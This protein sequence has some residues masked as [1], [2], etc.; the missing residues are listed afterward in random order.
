MKF[1]VICPVYNSMHYL[2]RCISS[3]LNQSF[4]DFE[5]LLLDDGSTDNSLSIC[6]KYESI[7]KRIR[8]FSGANIGPYNERILGYKKS[9]G[10]YIL[11]I[12]SDDAFVKNAFSRIN[13]A[14]EKHDPDV[15][16][17]NSYSEEK[18]IINVLDKTNY[19][20]QV[21]SDY[22]NIFVTF[23]DNYQLKQGLGRKCFKRSLLQKIDLSFRKYRI[24]EDGLFSIKL[25]NVTDSLML[26]N[27]CLYNYIHVNSTSLTKEYSK[28]AN[29]SF[30]VLREKIEIIVKNDNI[31]EK[32][33]KFCNTQ[34]IR[35]FLAYIVSRCKEIKTFEKKKNFLTN[36]VEDKDYNYLLNTKINLN[37]IAKL[38]YV[39]LLLKLKFYSCLCLILR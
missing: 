39:R 14:I 36:C 9:L 18:G 32:T 27:D 3:I 30:D 2:D 7:D 13:E 29:F 21:I 19:Q 8:V 28:N 31:S 4:Q 6:R 26:I 5:L 22:N 1:S 20:E 38:K 34:I 16:I 25:I 10:D 37:K 12:D 35:I 17:F 33:R 24:F 23:F 15:L 11:H